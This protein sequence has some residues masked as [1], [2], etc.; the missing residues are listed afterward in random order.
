[1][2]AIHTPTLPD[3]KAGEPTT[4]VDLTDDTGAQA[5]EYAMLGGAGAATVSLLAYCTRQ[6]WFQAIIEDL[7]TGVFDRLFDTI[8][9]LL[10]F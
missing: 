10:P 2:S 7:F 1:M 5:M 8:A 6:D 3:T 9:N 4:R